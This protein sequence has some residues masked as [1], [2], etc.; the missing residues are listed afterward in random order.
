M[1]KTNGAPRILLVDDERASRDIIG[2][3]LS[4]HGYEVDTADDGSGAMSLAEENQYRLAILDYRMP[5]MNG[6]QLF[7]KIH[8]MQPGIVGIFLTG[9][10]TVDTVFPA[11]QAGVSRVLAKPVDVHELLDVISGSMESAD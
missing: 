9:Y 7:E 11:V 1:A 5:G 3:I 4:L 6:V 10:P 2:E 8:Q